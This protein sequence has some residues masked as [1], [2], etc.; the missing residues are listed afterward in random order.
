MGYREIEQ[1]LGQFV[2]SRQHMNPLLV[3]SAS[4]ST[5]QEGTVIRRCVPAVNP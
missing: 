1:H 4:K 2:R 3:M 5:L